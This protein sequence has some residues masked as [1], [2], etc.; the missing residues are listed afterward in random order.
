MSP[1][2]HTCGVVNVHIA[3]LHILKK[4]SF[5]IEESG[6]DS[7][8]SCRQLMVLSCASLFQKLL[9]EDDVKVAADAMKELE[10]FMPSV[11]GSETKNKSK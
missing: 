10:M 9:D 2:Q 7:P 6:P 11:S 3:S 4:H 5:I 8:L 1:L